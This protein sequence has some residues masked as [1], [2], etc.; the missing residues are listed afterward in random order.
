MRLPQSTVLSTNCLNRVFDKTVATYKFYWFLGIL[1][2][3][4]KEGKTKFTVWDIA[5]YMISHAWY[6]VVYFKLSFGKSESLFDT[7]FKLQEKYS[8]PSNIDL[9]DL[10]I[11][12]KHLLETSNLKQDIN[13]IQLNV[14][15]RFLNPWIGT[16]SDKEMV[17]RSQ[18]YENDCL[19]K[20]ERIKGTLYIELNPKWFDY[21]RENYCIL[22]DFIFWNLTLFLQVRNPNV[23]NISNKLIRSESRSSLTPQRN[24]W[25]NVMN[26]GMHINCIYTGKELSIDQ[27]DLDHFMPWSF[28]SHDLLWNLMP[29]DPS[30]NSSKSNKIPNLDVY[31]PKLALT[32]QKA[33]KVSFETSRRN[34]LLEDYL[35]LGATPEEIINMT[36]V[37][38]YNCFR[39]TFSPMV[40]IATNMGFET[41][42]CAI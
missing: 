42:N 5:V 29:S 8:I 7:I 3:F 14:P 40:Q 33:L 4:V 18:T 20:I 36:E 30:I 35:S 41:W 12:L 24:Y 17:E 2:L 25:N 37:Q 22:H 31:L 39:N 1:E 13:F 38:L 10:R 9:K 6:P 28:V 21:L 16:P 32:H 27:F 15:F 23:P 19:Y 26:L 34:K 11:L